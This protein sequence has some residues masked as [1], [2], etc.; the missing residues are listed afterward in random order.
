MVLE[1]LGDARSEAEIS[2][3]LQAEWFGVPSGRV[4]RLVAWG[5]RVRY[6]QSSLGQLQT[7]LAKGIPV[8]LFLRTAGL[9]GWEEDMPHAVVLAGL[10][11]DEAF[12]YDPAKETGPL[13]VGLDALLIAWAE[14]D[15]YAAVI[16]R[17]ESG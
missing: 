1:F 7:D 12:F 4:T 16:G 2:T 11:I 14:M 15:Y 10:T 8:I 6:E 13:Q 9:P 5:Y 3:L 17:A